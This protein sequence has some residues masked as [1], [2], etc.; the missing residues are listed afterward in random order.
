LEALREFLIKTGDFRDPST[1]SEYTDKQL[2]EIDNIH[3]YYDNLH[4]IHKTN[5]KI[6]KQKEQKEQINEKE[7]DNFFKSVF[8]ASKN[9][10]FYERIK[11]KE[12]EQL[13]Y[14]RLLDSICDDIVKF[15]NENIKD[16]LFTLE[17]VYLHDYRI[18]FRRLINRSTTHAEY[19]INR[20]IENLNQI[21]RKEQTYNNNQCNICEYVIIFLEQLREEIY[22]S[23]N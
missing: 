10:K 20:N 3:N 11:E 5:N 18:H 21:L 14:E 13:I 1:R 12:Q 22:I 17:T 15:I 23:L 7:K 16:C 4:P 6:K 8:K 19:V 9:K 2:L